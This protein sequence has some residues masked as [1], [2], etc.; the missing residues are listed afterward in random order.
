MAACSLLIAICCTTWAPFGVRRRAAYAPTKTN[1]S[2]SP[3]AGQTATTVRGRKYDPAIR[4]FVDVLGSELIDDSASLTNDGGPQERRPKALGAVTVLTRGEEEES[5]E[6]RP[7]MPT[8]RERSI[9]AVTGQPEEPAPERLSHRLAFRGPYPFTNP[10]IE[11]LIAAHLLDSLD[12]AGVGH[13][14]DSLRVL[15]LEGV[16]EVTLTGASAADIRQGI[17][18][19]AGAPDSRWDIAS[20]EEVE[21][22]EAQH[23][24]LEADEIKATYAD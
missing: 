14:P 21:G 4:F 5:D 19:D 2:T 8:A 17:L 23:E 15:R 12:E 3:A 6:R 1:S 16:A 18:I 7:P 9:N 20:A 13:D 11:A 22:W 24:T 10:D